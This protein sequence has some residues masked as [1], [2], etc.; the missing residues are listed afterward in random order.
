[1]PISTKSDIIQCLFA[2]N[3]RQIPSAA[4]QKPQTVPASL[5]P[6][7]LVLTAPGYWISI[8]SPP[9]ERPKATAFW[10]TSSTPTV[11]YPEIWITKPA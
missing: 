7:T 1:M 3:D 10:P 6:H 5:R 11:L 2:T 9:G 8:Q 4:F